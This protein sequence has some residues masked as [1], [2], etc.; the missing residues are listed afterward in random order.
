MTQERPDLASS[1]P[2]KPPVELDQAGG[3]DLNAPNESDYVPITPTDLA[4]KAKEINRILQDA[5][6]HKTQVVKR[7]M[8][9]RTPSITTGLGSRL[10]NLRT[11]FSLVTVINHIADNQYQQ[12]KKQAK[13]ALGLAQASNDKL[14]V[15]RC[16][17]WLGR[18]EFETQNMQAAQAHF[19]AA[20][21]CIMDDINPEGKT[22]EFYLNA[23]RTGISK[24]Y[25][26][27]ILT[28]YSLTLIQSAPRETPFRR[29]NLSSQKRKRESQLWKVVLRPAS[30]DKTGMRQKQSRERS[31]SK[32]PEKLNKWIVRDIPDLPFRPKDGSGTS[33]SDQTSSDEH[34]IQDDMNATEQQ[35]GSVRIKSSAL[36]R[37]A[38]E[39]GMEWLQGANSRPRLEQLGEFTLRCYPVGLAPRTRSTDIFSRLPDEVLLSIQEWKSLEESMSN[40]AI[41][42]AYLAKE[43]QLRLSNNGNFSRVYGTERK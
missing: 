16:H 43:R 20:R 15:A 8:L 18:I 19:F 42:M 29:S 33:M 23:S 36:E 7:I 30:T 3:E 12:A 13:K 1:Q 14:S 25:L 17:Y 37:G 10:G 21:P 26:K 40:R 9:K 5:H 28:Q 24:E 35:A 39:E 38:S 27:R 41:T 4:E 11:S 34:R 22:L 2:K 31:K 32:S 6:Q